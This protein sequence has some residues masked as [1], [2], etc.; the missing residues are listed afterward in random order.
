[1]RKN[2]DIELQ[3]EQDF[4][5]VFKNK[6]AKSFTFI[7]ISDRKVDQNV[8]QEEEKDAFAPLDEKV[9]QNSDIDLS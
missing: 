3:L 8:D 1:L 6:N 4:K 7:P 2:E 9:F 5:I